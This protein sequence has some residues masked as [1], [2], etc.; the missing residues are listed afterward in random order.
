MLDD[1]FT[2]LND[3]FNPLDAALA[4]ALWNIDSQIPQEVLLAAALLSLNLSR[5]NVALNL[6]TLSFRHFFPSP[7]KLPQ[8]LE[9]AILALKDFDFRN[10]SAV[11]F[12]EKKEDWE[13]LPPK[14]LLYWKGKLYLWRY[15]LAERK[16]EENILKRLK[17]L[18][19]EC[20]NLILNKLFENEEQKNACATAF[21]ENF[22]VITG[23]PGTGKTYT[24][25]RL[26]ALLLSE[27]P[28][29]KIALAAPTGKAAQRLKESI[30]R[31]VNDLKKDFPHLDLSS[32]NPSTLHRLLGVTPTGF[33]HNAAY[34]LDLDVLIVDEAS[35]VDL[36]L[37]ESLLKALTP[38]TK[39]VLL[40]DKNQLASVDAGCLLGE[41]CN[42]P[43]LNSNITLLKRSRRFKENTGIAE[44]SH[45]INEGKSTGLENLFNGEYEDLNLIQTPKE[46]ETLMNDFYQN[47]ILLPPEKTENEASFTLYAQKIIERNLKLQVLCAL[48]NGEFGVKGFNQTIENIQKKFTV[49]RGNSLFFE[50][51]PVMMNE[52]RVHLGLSNGDLGV[53][54]SFWIHNEWKT[55]FVFSSNPRWFSPMRLENCVEKMFALTIHKAQGSEFEHVIVVLPPKL[56]PILTRELLYTG[57]TR[58]QKKLTLYIP[59]EAQPFDL[60]KK[61]VNNRLNRQGALFEP[62]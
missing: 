27:N 26:L 15:F 45:L 1:F 58:A 47:N 28:H 61:I 41:I 9:N 11:F 42:A 49:S 33:K 37:F 29:L 13:N 53:A 6:N 51:C 62:F 30:E 12:V 2:L 4:R 55:R 17:T 16:V 14:P 18:K 48:R 23:G 59:E 34:P 8:T 57:A 39:L 7:K 35:M 46:F 32:L 60:L 43:I 10:Q 25:A 22:S 19:K 38:H 52:N 24:V 36:L 56:L 3:F 20:N 54:L 40:G 21:K 44:F 5:G 50:Q 31:S